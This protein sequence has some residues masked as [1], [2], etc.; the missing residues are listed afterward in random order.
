MVGDEKMPKILAPAIAKGSK[1]LGSSISA[2][3]VLKGVDTLSSAAKLHG[4]I[5]ELSKP[6]GR[7]PA[8]GSERHQGGRLI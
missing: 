8:T 5:R 1:L 2:K 6:I 3:D 7:Q 4:S